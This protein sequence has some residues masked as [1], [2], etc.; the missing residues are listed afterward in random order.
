[1]YFP[2]VDQPKNALSL[3]ILAVEH[4]NARADHIGRRL[5]RKY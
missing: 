5:F 1:M 4:R 2:A 3:T